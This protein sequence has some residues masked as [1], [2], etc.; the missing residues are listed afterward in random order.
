M[1][2]WPTDLSVEIPGNKLSSCVA[3][4]ARLSPRRNGSEYNLIYAWKQH[5]LTPTRKSVVNFW[6]SG[7]RA[8]AANGTDPRVA[9]NTGP[10]ASTSLER[11]TRK[12]KRRL[13]YRLLHTCYYYYCYYKRQIYPA[14]S[15]AS[16]TGDNVNCII[17]TTT[18]K[19]A[20]RRRPLCAVIGDLEET[21]EHTHTH[22]HLHTHL[23]KQSFDVWCS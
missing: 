10:T 18:V 11:V 8:S 23:F 16:K 22:T 6:L 12:E 17:R 9:Q 14:V 4:V 5:C 1:E 2:T 3:K 20:T 15:E 19:R 13:S 21:L 7:P